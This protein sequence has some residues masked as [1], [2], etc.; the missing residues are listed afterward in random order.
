MLDEEFNERTRQL[1]AEVSDD[2]YPPWLPSSWR[3]N[4]GEEEDVSNE[5]YPPGQSDREEPWGREPPNR[6]EEEPLSMDEEEPLSMD[7]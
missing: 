4:N 5:G 7:F 2:G 6:E 3:Q 1:L